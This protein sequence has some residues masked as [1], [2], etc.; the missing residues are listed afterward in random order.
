MILILI[1]GSKAKLKEKSIEDTNASFCFNTQ[2]KSS[3]NWSKFK[4][5][6]MLKVSNLSPLVLLTPPPSRRR[7]GGRRR[8]GFNLT[9]WKNVNQGKQMKYKDFYSVVST[10]CRSSLPFFDVDTS[11]MP[12][13]KYSILLPTYEERENLPI[14]IWLIVKYMKERYEYCSE[15]LFYLAPGRDK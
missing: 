6:K 4:K 5:R 7:T 13:N 1:T 9:E 8:P 15:K 14:I 3:I 11:K 10:G 2:L 12:K